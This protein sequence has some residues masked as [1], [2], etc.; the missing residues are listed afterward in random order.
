M[1]PIGV[2]LTFIIIRATSLYLLGKRC[3]FQFGGTD[4]LTTGV[5]VS[6]SMSRDGPIYRI[7]TTNTFSWLEKP[8]T[9]YSLWIAAYGRS[10]MAGN[11]DA[12]LREQRESCM[13]TN[14]D[15]L[16]REQWDAITVTATSAVAKTSSFN[17]LTSAYTKTTNKPLQKQTWLFTSTQ[18]R[19]L[20]D[21]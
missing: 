6:F 14:V 1:S 18:H 12:A 20:Q 5:K 21:K 19:Y 15:A 2:F 17:S 3:K 11:V 16:L 8:A 10:C 7:T 4:R 13:A 9:L